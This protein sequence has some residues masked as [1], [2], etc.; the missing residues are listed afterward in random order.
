MLKA[1]RLPSFHQHIS[2]TI[3]PSHRCTKNLSLLPYSRTKPPSSHPPSTPQTSQPYHLKNPQ[4]HTPR[5]PKMSTNPAPDSSIVRF[6]DPKVQAP[7]QSGRTLSSI[8]ALPD[9]TLE[10][11]HDYIQQLFPLPERSRIHPSA[12]TID[13][14]TFTAFRSRPDLQHQLIRSLTR[15]LHFYGLEQSQTQNGPPPSQPI[16][17]SI[18]PGANFPTASPNWVTRSSHNHLRITRIIRSLRVLGLEAHAR[19][20]FLAL[21]SV[22][23]DGK[24]GIGGRSMAFWARAAERPLYLAPEDERDGGKGK[25]FLY[26]YEAGR[27]VG[28]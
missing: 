26:E 21:V 9:S 23:D 14:S 17:I 5:S 27:Q 11:C 18:S 3:T 19:A 20:F 13:Q 24:S 28:G 1:P 10:H 7:D 15:L 4:H 22:Y 6:Y 12:P 8:L 2:S 25:D 16:P